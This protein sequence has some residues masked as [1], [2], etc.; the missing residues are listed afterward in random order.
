MEPGTKPESALYETIRSQPGALRAIIDNTSNE[1]VAAS[2]AVLAS[3]KVLLLGTGTSYHAAV[4][5]E[6]LLRM[7][8]VDA[9][10]ATNFEFVNYGRGV[11]PDDAVITISHKGSK[12]YGRRAIGLAMEA[13]ARVIG[14]TRHDSPMEGAEIRISTVEIERSATHTV[15]YTSAL[16]VLALLATKVG[17]KTGARVGGLEGAVVSLP[18][19]LAFL[20]EREEEAMP[21]AEKLA[22]R[23][24]FVLAGA[25]PNCVTAKEGAL[26][27]KESS[28][29]VAEGFELETILHG[30]LQAVEAGDVAAVIAADGPALK[31]TADLVRALMTIGAHVFLV[32][33]ERTV[34]R[35]P[36]AEIRHREGTVFPFPAVPEQ[37]SPALA[38][39][40]LQIL[41]AFTAALRATDADSF[42]KDE[43][44]YKQAVEGYEL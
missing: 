14:I 42:R 30:G 39:V 9:Y 29:L 26:K 38:V 6:H 3:G 24:R 17:E 10:A 1:I 34:G 36:V 44:V 33:D 40:P 43:P 22:S 19:H 35:L 5:G 15:S 16:T 25:G 11:G 20:L 8:G 31:R 2:G 13:G 27:V 4:V 28:Y 7:A 23:G 12:L 32:A 41:A 37:L 18:D 21:T